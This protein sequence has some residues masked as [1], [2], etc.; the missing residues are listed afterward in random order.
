MCSALPRPTV[1]WADSVSGAPRGP[2]TLPC[3][4]RIVR[5]RCFSRG[6][7]TFRLDYGFSRTRRRWLVDVAV[8]TLVGAQRPDVGPRRVRGEVAVFGRDFAERA[9]DVFGHRVSGAADV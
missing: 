3:H 9:I 4:E 2:I 5:Q 8:G 7:G 1:H 6:C